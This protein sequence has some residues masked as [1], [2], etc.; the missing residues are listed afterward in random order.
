ML[1][2]GVTKKKN[3]KNNFLTKLK[4]FKEV[5]SLTKTLEVKDNWDS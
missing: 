4:C 1:G 2:H 5:T 3:S